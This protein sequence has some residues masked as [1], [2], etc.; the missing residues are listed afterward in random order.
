MLCR[1]CGTQLTDDAKF[2][3]VCGVQTATEQTA[4]QEQK[5]QNYDANLDKSMSGSVWLTV[6][7]AVFSL[8][9]VFIFGFESGEGIVTSVTA[10]AFSMFILGIKW[11][12]EIKNQRKWKK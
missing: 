12:Y 1:N 3:N 2:C 9:I 10:I 7:I 4:I 8:V 11:F 6:G 5:A